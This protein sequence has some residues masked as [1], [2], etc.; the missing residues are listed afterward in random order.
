MEDGKSSESHLISA[1]AYVEAGVQDAC[2]DACSIC[3]EE[4]N[5]NEPSSVRVS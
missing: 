5:E 4:F 3:L 2:D 1:A